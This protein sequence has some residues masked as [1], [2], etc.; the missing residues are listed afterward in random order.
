MRIVGGNHKGRVLKGP[1][2]SAQTRPTSDRVRESLYNI[3]ASYITGADFLD[4]F[5]GTGAVGLEA[6]SRG[7]KRLVMVEKDRKMVQI[8]KHN[9]TI[10]GEDAEILP[11]DVYKAITELKNK[12]DIFDIVFADPPYH[13]QAA[14]K[15]CEL[16]EPLLSVGGLFVMEHS[17]NEKIEQ[18]KL[19]NIK[20]YTY[21]ESVLSL[22]KRR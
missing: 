16:V 8:I 15:L 21:G 1:P 12:E 14:S 11:R 20:S 10:L 19:E 4:L 5:A 6:Q 3:L 13:L 2:D 17:A 18:D 9:M 22:F 7:A